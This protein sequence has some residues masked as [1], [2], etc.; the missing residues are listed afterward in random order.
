[1]AYSAITYRDGI[2]PRQ[3]DV[4]C[5]VTDT[6]GLG[7]LPGISGTFCVGIQHMSRQGRV[8]IKLL[9]I[10]WIVVIGLTLLP[11]PAPA[12]PHEPRQ[13]SGAQPSLGS[14][15]DNQYRNDFFRMRYEFPKD[16]HVDKAAMDHA[17]S[18]AETFL[19]S[20]GKDPNHN[21]WAGYRSLGLLKI[22]K[23]PADGLRVHGPRITLDAS[24]VTPKLQTSSDVLNGFKRTLSEQP[25]A[26][27]IRDLT[28]CSFGGRNFV[29]LDVKWELPGGGA[30]YEG[31]AITVVNGYFVEFQIFADTRD[32]LDD[33]YRTLD[34]LQFAS[35]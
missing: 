10:I 6:R 35:E 31:D 5:T 24:S 4:R 8:D 28:E 26:R 23:L 21:A 3:M 16:W 18:D 30:S 22:S 7:R 13:S 12:A 2:M 1:M 33:L 9:R 11:T 17:N 15:L 25:N 32:E 19:S 29:R 14:I 27:I 20:S 34:S